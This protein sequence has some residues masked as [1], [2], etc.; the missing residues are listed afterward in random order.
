MRTGIVC[1]C[2]IAFMGCA[3]FEKYQNKGTPQ[4]EE[5]RMSACP[6]DVCDTGKEP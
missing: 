2:L 1:A 4:W 5:L 3:R 6:D